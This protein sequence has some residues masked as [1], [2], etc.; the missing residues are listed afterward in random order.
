M[1]ITIL[2]KADWLIAGVISI[3]LACVAA[4]AGINDH[5]SNFMV[6]SWSNLLVLYST[7]ASVSAS[8]LGFT[9]TAVTIIISFGKFLEPIA[10]EDRFK[11]LL[12]VYKYTIFWLFVACVLAFLSILFGNE[13]QV[14]LYDLY[15]LCFFGLII[16]SRIFL[17][18]HLL[19]T[20][21][22]S[23]GTQLQSNPI[24]STD[25]D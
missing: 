16:A 19:M 17:C 14:A 10:K 11:E 15:L 21:A 2:Q 23:F 18:V 24:K 7:A 1:L 4:N 3:T 5:I 25:P 9:I 12:S 8:I 22:E 13:K 6:A 20:I